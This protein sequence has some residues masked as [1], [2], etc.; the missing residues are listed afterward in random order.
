MLEGIDGVVLIKNSADKKVAQIC[1]ETRQ[2]TTTGVAEYNLD[3]TEKEI[4]WHL[5]IIPG[6]AC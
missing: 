2:L 1:M 6:S 4:S 3:L 5:S